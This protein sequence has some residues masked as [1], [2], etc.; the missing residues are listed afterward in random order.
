MVLQTTVEHRR[1]I[2]YLATRPEIDAGRIG[3]LGLSM[4]GMIT[5]ALNACEPRVRA[6]VA[7]VTPLNIWGPRELAVVSPFTFARGV[8]KRP[9][10]MLMGR[11]DPS[12]SA[13]EA[14]LLLEMIEG[15]P[16][17]LLFYDSGHR[18]PEEYVAR[19]RQWFED[20]LKAATT[21]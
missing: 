10:L 5:F 19:A 6:S 4:G 7:G 15:R 3:V 1:A 20:H 11:T 2:D 12:Y 17:Q 18:L 14:E 16:K 9:F 21:P 13:A 8:G